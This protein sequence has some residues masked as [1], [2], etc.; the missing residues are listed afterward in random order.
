MQWF[1]LL[2]SVLLGA[3]KSVLSKKINTADGSLKG[4][5]RANVFLF[6]F[7]F[8]FV[9]LFALFS[10]ENF[11]V[12][13]GLTA[14]YAAC[15][16]FSQISLMKAVEYGSVAVSSLFYS[17]GFVLPVIFGIAY[18]KEPFNAL[19]VVGILLILTSFILSAEK[20]Q[21]NLNA[22]W[23]VFALGGTV[24]SGL[25]G[26][27]QKLFAAQTT[28]Y[29]LDLFLCTAFLFIVS[30]SAAI[31]LLLAFREKKTPNAGGNPSTFTENDGNCPAKNDGENKK[32]SRFLPLLFTAALGFVTGGVNKLNT[33]LAGILPSVLVFPA[34]NGGVIVASAVFSAILFKEKL[35]KKQISAICIGFIAIVLI[36]IA[37]NI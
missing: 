26:I 10:V 24:F 27:I 21:Q 33:Y 22:K 32:K 36:A 37:Q 23:L 2:C 7:A 14:S 4:T 28:P 15:V 18:F 31:Y 29:S 9:A 8:C 25:V 12:P 20:S 3:S 13:W 5:M 30:F 19:H 6:F 16:L 11:S 1:L 34:T 17:C 35:S